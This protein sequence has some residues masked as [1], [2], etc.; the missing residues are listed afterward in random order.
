MEKNKSAAQQPSCKDEQLIQMPRKRAMGWIV[1]FCFISVWIFLL[2]ILVGRGMAPVQFD[3]NALQKDLADLRLALINKELQL[4][5]SDTT[6]LTEKPDFEF[7]ENLKE[8]KPDT[9]VS[10]QTETPEPTEISQTGK[11]SHK[12]RT[13]IKKKQLADKPEKPSLPKQEPSPADADLSEKK[14]TI[15]IASLRD[16]KEADQLI[17]TLQKQGI[18]AY[19]SVGVLSK[20]NIWYRV[21]AGYFSSKEESQ[22]MMAKIKKTHNGAILLK[23]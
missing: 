14:M 23:Q 4:T 8:S 6:I 5:K 17:S 16:S 18:P 9:S 15:Q 3:I 19:K 12:T 11:P 20:D 13:V 7:H 2:G 22:A 21:R 10:F 1:I